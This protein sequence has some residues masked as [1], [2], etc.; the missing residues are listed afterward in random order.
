MSATLRERGNMMATWGSKPCCRGRG[1]REGRECETLQVSVYALAWMVF[2]S[3][4]TEG[5]GVS[6]PA[7]GGGGKKEER[8]EKEDVL[9]D[10]TW[11]SL[12]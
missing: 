1:R 11:A 4:D 2:L 6:R 8:K 10:G 5:G 3:L 7:R 9:D 12:G